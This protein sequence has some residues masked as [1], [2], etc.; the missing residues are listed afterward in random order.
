MSVFSQ[1]PASVLQWFAIFLSIIIEALPFVLLGTIFS[2]AIEVFVTPDRVQHYLPKGKV[3]RIL[4]GTFVGFVFLPVNV[5]LFP[6]S[7]VFWR[8]KF[9]A[10]LRFHF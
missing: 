1:L 10:T 6:S 3:A 9:P 8:R 5:G 4:F 2:G 7:T